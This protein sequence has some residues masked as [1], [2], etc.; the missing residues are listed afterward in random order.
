MK[1]IAR[2][3]F[4]NLHRI[5]YEE[6]PRRSLFFIG[7]ADYATLP[8][9]PYRTET[10]GVCL[11]RDGRVGL[12]TG[13]TDHEVQGPSV[14]TMGPAVIRSWQELDNETNSSILFFTA[15]YLLQDQVDIHLLS[16]FRYFEDNDRHVSPLSLESLDQLDRIFE[17]IQTLVASRHI[18]RLTLV[19]HYVSILLYE[20][21]AIHRVDKSPIHATENY[22]GILAQRFKAQLAQDFREHHDVAHYADQLYVTSKYLSEKVKQETGRTTSEWIHEVIVLEARVL[23]QDLSLSITQVSQQLNFPSVS[24]FGKFFKKYVGCSPREYR[25]DRLASKRKF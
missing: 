16:S 17:T 7:K 18:Y 8:T 14:I 23:L 19:R 25:Q 3:G 13:I 22:L 4:N 20:I 2:Y 10:Y 6:E 15:E 24:T 1:P 5:F 11:F 21:D 12:R 9:E